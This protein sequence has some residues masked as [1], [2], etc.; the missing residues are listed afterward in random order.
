MMDN[1]HFQVGGRLASSGAG[2]ATLFGDGRVEVGDF[3][4]KVNALLSS[5]D[6]R[7]AA[8]K[9]RKGFAEAGGAPAARSAIEAIA[10]R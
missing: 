5:A 1:D 2:I 4:A 3:R 7:A 9:V 10:Q 8:D 6:M